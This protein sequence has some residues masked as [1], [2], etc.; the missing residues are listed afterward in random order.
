MTDERIIEDK[1]YILMPKILTAENGAENILC[2]KFYEKIIFNG[3]GWMDE[4]AGE[5]EGVQ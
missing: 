5:A 4:E 3:E 1:D 2:G